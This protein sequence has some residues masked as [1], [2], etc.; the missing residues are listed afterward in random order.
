MPF[1]ADTGK[2]YKPT[3][4]EMKLALAAQ[5]YAES[6]QPPSTYQATVNHFLRIGMQRARAI[7]SRREAA[8]AK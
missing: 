6:R 4:I 7:P 2:P 8:A 5:R 3:K 1:K